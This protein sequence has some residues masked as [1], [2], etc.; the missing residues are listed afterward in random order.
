M[1]NPP[2]FWTG[3]KVLVTGAAGFVG[4]W[5]VEELLAEGAKVLAADLLLR[6]QPKNLATVMDR[7]IFKHADLCDYA[8]CRHLAEDVDAV[9]HLAAKVAGIAYNSTHPATMLN[10][11]LTLSGNMLE[12]SRRESVERYLCVS[13]PMVYPNDAPV[14]TPEDV[15]LAG[16]PEQAHFGY[17]WAKR[18][19]EVQA[20]AYY[21]EYGMKIGIVRPYNIYGPRD[22]FSVETGH[23]I[24][25]LVVKAMAANGSLKVLG[26]GKQIRSFIH[27]RDVAR[28]MMEVL[29][30]LPTARPVN[31]AT[32]EEISIG[33]LAHK[34][35]ELM[36]RNVKIEF[37]ASAP[38]GVL[39]R[40]ADTTRL[41]EEVGY[42][43][44]ITLEQGLAETVRWYQEQKGIQD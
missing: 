34:I 16:E 30:H 42:T 11:N 9:F 28:G 29:E 21:A 41:T 36:G 3:R 32:Q 20:C 18:L 44:Q 43:P 40:C 10:A 24:P 13:S 14:P 39:R 37:D 26:S 2:S 8:T 6:G 1:S 4:S 15:G 17:G 19:S 27:V 12:A 35:V 38:A 33:D 7:I 22:D 25:S 23:V 5:L 31:L